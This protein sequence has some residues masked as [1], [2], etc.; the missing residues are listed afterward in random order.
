MRDRVV[1]PCLAIILCP[2]IVV[3]GVVSLIGHNIRSNRAYKNTRPVPPKPLPRKRRALSQSLFDWTA[4]PKCH[5]LN[6]LPPEIR[7][8][9]YKYVL[10]GNV[11]HLVQGKRRISHVRCRASSE[12]DFVRSCRPAAA[13]TGS[14][15]LPGSTSN[16]NL[17]LLRTCRRVYQEAID[18]L[19]A[20]N[21]F[22]VD[23]PRTLLYLAQTI[24]PQRLAS[25]TKLHI[26]CPIQCVFWFPHDQ[27]VSLWEPPYDVT[28]WELFWHVIAARMPR[29]AELSI[30]L[31]VGYSFPPLEVSDIWVRPLLA[32]R[33][34]KKFDFDVV[35]NYDRNADVSSLKVAP[36]R[37]CLRDVVC[38]EKVDSA[39]LA[40]F[41]IQFRKGFK[42]WIGKHMGSSTAKT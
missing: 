42:G 13:N 25:I 27:N 33:G 37:Q 10:G 4:S 12:T 35:Y 20:S 3:I 16:A 26:Y 32:V 39:P 1:E 9:I 7:L 15:L 38:A 5:L 28:T 18:V 19:Y 36:F 29:L 22:D 31:G 40:D 17:A 24:R 6:R 41:S 11:L 34:L 23:D 14:E 21:T 2:C 30:C 8:E